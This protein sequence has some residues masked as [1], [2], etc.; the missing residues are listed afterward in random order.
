MT[1]PHRVVVR[2]PNWL[3]D[4]V[5][6]APAIRALADA[7]PDAAIEVAVPAGLAPIVPLLDPRATALPL[8]GRTGLR[9]VRRHA[10]QIRAA[11]YDL[12][13]LLTNSFGSAL[14]PFLAEHFSRAV[15]LWEYDVM[16]STVR[17]ERPQ[18][19]IQEWAGRR[20]YTRLP[21]DAVADDRG[22][23]DE[24]ARV[25]SSRAARR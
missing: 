3:G 19:V 25:S 1:S 15:F 16:P 18:V 21:W 23:A 4:L 24:A 6:A 12:A 9:A 11:G 8:Q 20:L 14:V 22:A 5:M 2:G 13:L 7:W 10:D 17:Q